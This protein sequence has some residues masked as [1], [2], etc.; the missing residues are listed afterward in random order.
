LLPCQLVT[1]E[2]V[3]Q[4]GK[5]GAAADAPDHHVRVRAR[6]LH[7][8]LCFEADHGLVEEDVIHHRTERVLGIVVGGRVLDGFGDRDPE[9]AG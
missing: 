2:W 6:H 1:D 5:I 3:R 4:A 9:A 8:L 7:L